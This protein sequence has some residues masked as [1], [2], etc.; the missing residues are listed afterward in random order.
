M[1]NIVFWAVAILATLWNLFG[2]FDFIMT[3]TNNQA[4]LENAPADMMAWIHGLPMWRIALWGLCIGVSL[5]ACL[6]LLLRRTMAPRLF[7]ITVALMI[8]ALGYDVAIGGVGRLLGPGY[9]G[10]ACFLIAIEV[11]FA[12][13]AGWAARQGMLKPAMR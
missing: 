8:V 10:F 13:Y 4:Y 2:S 12:L 6:A 9:V 11:L 7:W 3:V 5:L 1:R